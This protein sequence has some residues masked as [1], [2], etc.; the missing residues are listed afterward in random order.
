MLEDSHDTVVTGE[1]PTSLELP[2]HHCDM[3]LPFPP[4]HTSPVH[5]V[6]AVTRLIP[7][8]LCSN[9]GMA[10]SITPAWLCKGHRDTSSLC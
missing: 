4:A 5:H 9:G 1:E 8:R 7:A 10:D 3:G 2:G 6:T